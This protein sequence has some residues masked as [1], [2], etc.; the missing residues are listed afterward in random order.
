M[1]G[2]CFVVFLYIGVTIYAKQYSDKTSTDIAVSE[3]TAL[4]ENKPELTENALLSDAV[5]NDPPKY[6]Q[7]KLSSKKITTEA[8]QATIVSEGPISAQYESIIANYATSGPVSNIYY[9]DTTKSYPDLGN[10]LKDHLKGKLLWSNSDISY[11]YEIRIVDCQDCSYGGLYTGSYLYGSPTDITKAFG[12]ITLNV[13]PYK[14]SAYFNDYMKLILS[15][16]YGHHYTLYH[17]FVDFD[18]PTGERF[19]SAYYST[20]PLSLASTKTDYSLG[21]ENCDVEIMAEDYSY[22]FSGY[23][24]HAMSSIYNYPS[25]ALKNWFYSLSNQPA[26]SDTSAPVV[27][28]TSP[29]NNAT[30]SGI[31]NI[32]I[33]ASD[34]VGVTRVEIYIDGNKVSTLLSPPYSFAWET[35]SYQ[36]GDHS[37]TAKAYDSTQSAEASI[38]ANVN[39]TVSDTEAPD[40][41]ISDPVLSPYN[42]AGGNMRITASATDNIAVTKIEIYINNTLVA[43]ENSG[44]IDR[45]W[46]GSS[47]PIG[48]YSLDIKAYDSAGNIGSKTVI[49]HKT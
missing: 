26:P 40:I 24:Y 21:W 16:E 17:R 20:R 10:A 6:N 19:P 43:S 29:Q 44:S 45:I 42:W 7:S 14:N 30:V 28:I 2:F 32:T 15:H 5:K 13:A 8:G 18:I 27:S 3:E 38:N 41:T 33:S 25:L 1:I 35:R 49:V 4:T 39:N 34:N 48:D 36:N 11:L 31:T 37:V 23:G 47:T 12:F 9:N 46:I 22:I